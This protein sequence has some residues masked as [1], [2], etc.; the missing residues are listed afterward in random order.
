MPFSMVLE[1][2]ERPLYE[3]RHQSLKTQLQKIQ[4]RQRIWQKPQTLAETY[5]KCGFESKTIP[6]YLNTSGPYNDSIYGAVPWKIQPT[7]P[8]VLQKV[9]PSPSVLRHPFPAKFRG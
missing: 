1:F 6:I 7:I 8:Q 9:Q 3:N 4:N 2:P 5:Q